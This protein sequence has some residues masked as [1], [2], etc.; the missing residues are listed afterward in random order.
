MNKVLV[1]DKSLLQTLERN[2]RSVEN[3]QALA[4]NNSDEDSKTVDTALE[5]ARSKML[6][7]SQK[8][9][10]R[11]HPAHSNMVTHAERRALRELLKAIK[12]AQQTTTAVNELQDR[13]SNLKKALRVSGQAS[14]GRQ[15]SLQN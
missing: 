12:S 11:P 5:E 13:V 2:I 15:K 6:N 10:L 1:P 3:A 4:D 9:L 8:I 14:S 7:T